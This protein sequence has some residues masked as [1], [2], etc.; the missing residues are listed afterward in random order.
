MFPAT[1]LRSKP[2]INGNIL[3]IGLGNAIIPPHVEG[4][5]GVSAVRQAAPRAL[6][7]PWSSRHSNFPAFPEGSIRVWVRGRS[8]LLGILVL[9]PQTHSCGNRSSDCFMLIVSSFSGFH[10]KGLPSVKKSKLS[11]FLQFGTQTI[12]F[13]IV[14]FRNV[15]ICWR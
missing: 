7:A 9:H 5:F 13:L 4:F 8:P 12:L 3:W 14:R 1:L 10:P 11:L 15:W 6:E 2:S